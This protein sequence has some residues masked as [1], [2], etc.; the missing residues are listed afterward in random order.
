M[1][2][3]RYRSDITHERIPLRVRRLDEN[4]Y[5]VT[6][7]KGRGL[8]YRKRYDF[9]SEA[10]ALIDGAAG[11]EVVLEGWLNR[12]GRWSITGVLFELGCDVNSLAT[13]G[14]RGAEAAQASL[15]KA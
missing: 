2:E 8:E 9:T 3:P 5:R 10:L 4:R 1:R 13:D 7:A 15:A 11:K 12:S 14:S 6:D